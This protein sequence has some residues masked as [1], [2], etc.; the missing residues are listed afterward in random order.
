MSKI[1][2]FFKS[3]HIQLALAVGASIIAIAY[4]SKRVL[5]EPIGNLSAA[6]PAFVAVFYEAV[7]AKY[8]D[9]RVSTAWYWVVGVLA[10]TVVIILV[11]LLLDS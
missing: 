4:V 1:A 2:D 8:P 3:H 7:R 6:L 9:S 11:A 5:S 10:T